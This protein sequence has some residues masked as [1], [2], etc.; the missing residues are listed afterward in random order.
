[1]TNLNETLNE[2]LNEAGDY[3]LPEPTIMNDGV[4]AWLTQS[5]NYYCRAEPYPNWK[6][7]IYYGLD[8]NHIPLASGRC[9][10]C[11]EILESKYCGNFV[12]CPCRKSF[13]DT[14]RWT[15]EMHRYGGDIKP[16]TE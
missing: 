16:I 5:G 12:Q 14:D 8:K 9:G 10:S 11:D 1:M 7:L 4:E 13:V 6:K 3:V 2:Y 15:P